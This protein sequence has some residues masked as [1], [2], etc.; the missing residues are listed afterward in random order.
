MDNRMNKNR[1]RKEKGN[2]P[3]DSTYSVTQLTIQFQ[4]QCHKQTQAI[5]KQNKINK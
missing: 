5:T 2:S 4:F 3:A 1:D